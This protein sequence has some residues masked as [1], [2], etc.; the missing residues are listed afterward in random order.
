MHGMECQTLPS[1]CLGSRH[2]TLA[3]CPEVWLEEH[4]YILRNDFIRVQLLSLLC[5]IVAQ[6]AW[7][8]ESVRRRP[9]RL[10]MGRVVAR[11]C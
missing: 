6:V 8:Q 3:S 5:R 7:D 9:L 11:N 10:S 2:L 1:R 4:Q